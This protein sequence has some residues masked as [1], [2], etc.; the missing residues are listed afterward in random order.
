MKSNIKAVFFD[1]DDTLVA[2]REAKFA[3]HKH[4]AKVFYGKELTDADILPHWGKPLTQLVCLLYG[5]D[6]IEE[7]MANN[8]LCWD[9]FPKI[10]YPGTIPTLEYLNP[11]KN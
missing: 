11:A 1:H 2:T 6:N 9:D 3:H 8:V 10:L 5:T 7:A 4:V